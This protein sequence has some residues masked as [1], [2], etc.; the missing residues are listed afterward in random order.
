LADGLE[1]S[2]LG[3]DVRLISR[4]DVRAR[5]G[6]PLDLFVAALAW[7]YGDRGYG[8]FRA[9]RVFADNATADIERL[10]GALADLGPDD[11]AA[12]WR[13]CE[14]DHRL[15]HLGVAFST[16]VAHFAGYDAVA[17]RG[18]L[19]AD[20]NTAWGVWALSGREISNIR[21]DPEMYARYVN[22]AED[23][24]TSTMT[25]ADI[26]YAL[27][28]IG[29]AIRDACVGAGR[30]PRNSVAA[31]D[32]DAQLVLGASPLPSGG[33]QGRVDI[34]SSADAPTATVPR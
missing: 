13:A 25:P 8:S 10:V 27:F 11:P 26:E 21:T 9:A 20:V 17:H 24:A 4:S 30:P 16:K 18:P 7:G 19:I 15:K 5:Q 3:S 14:R 2:N 23:L 33:A 32:A 6:S 34:A 12:S 1:E 22:L 31:M 28:V 29:P